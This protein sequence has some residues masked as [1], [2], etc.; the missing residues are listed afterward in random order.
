[1]SLRENEKDTVLWRQFK[2][3]DEEAFVALFKDYYEHL[4]NYGIKMTDDYTLVEDCIQE[5]FLDLWRSQ[6]KAEINTLKA[7]FFRAFK[8]QLVRAIEKSKQR[9]DI[10]I[11]PTEEFEIS[12]ENILIDNHETEELK[13]KVLG[14]I[15]K[16]SPRQKEIIY[17]KFHHN[18]SYEEI[19]EIMQ[20]NY[21]ATRNLI[22]NSIKT[23]KKIVA[24]SP[25]FFIGLLFLLK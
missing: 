17:L 16:L 5:L 9:G 11:N 10:T 12:F 1:M 25:V 14:A 4:Y 6:G 8:Y 3:G 22:Y 18:L 23:I 24:A 13:K 20:I 21:Q 2:N 19:S 15:Q 7:Y